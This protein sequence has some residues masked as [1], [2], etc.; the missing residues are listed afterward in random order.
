MT[1]MAAVELLCLSRWFRAKLRSQ[2]LLNGHKI[3]FSIDSKT[4]MLQKL[5][6]ACHGKVN[7]AENPGWNA[8]ISN[9]RMTSD[10]TSRP[11]KDELYPLRVWKWSPSILREQ[12]CSASLGASWSAQRDLSLETSRLEKS[13][14][15]TEIKPTQTRLRTLTH[16]SHSLTFQ[17]FQNPTWRNSTAQDNQKLHNTEVKDFM[18]YIVQNLNIKFSFPPSRTFGGQIKCNKTLRHDIRS[19]FIFVS[20]SI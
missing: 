6:S 4:E 5:I 15:A 16:T 12:V 1:V 7:N 10:K 14:R 11:E 8:Q 2:S 9:T 19:R 3:K 17:D 13:Q 20:S 18:D